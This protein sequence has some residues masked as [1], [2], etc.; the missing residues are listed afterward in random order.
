VPE[1]ERGPVAAYAQDF[2]RFEQAPLVLAPY[3]RASNALGERFGMPAERDLGAVASVSAAIMN[4]LLAAHALGLG[5]CWMTGPL[6]AAPELEPL[7]GIPAG[8]RL[9]A[10]VPVGLP[11]ETPA[12]P[13]RRAVSH[14]LIR[15]GGVR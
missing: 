5:A 8:W 6:L 11:D 12:P 15:S 7:L 14:L 2:V 4:L 13:A 10:I 3:F 1:D 9:A